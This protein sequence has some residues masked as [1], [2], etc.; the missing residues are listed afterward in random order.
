MS[1]GCFRVRIADAA[2]RT[3]RR[4]G[5]KYGKKTYEVLRD[6]IRELEFNPCQK[7]EPLRT[8]LRGFYSLHYSRFR[9]IY[10]V[11]QGEAIVFVV[12]VGYHRAKSRWDVYRVLERLVEAGQLQMPSGNDTQNDEETQT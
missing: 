1:K 2:K 4:I 8:P 12:A 3:L 10:T 11:E 5:K 7:G 9:I 6:L